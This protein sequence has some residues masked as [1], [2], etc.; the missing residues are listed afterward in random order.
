MTCELCCI[1]LLLVKYILLQACE[2]VAAVTGKSF[3]RHRGVHAEMRIAAL[4][5]NYY[6]IMYCKFAKRSLRTTILVY[7]SHYDY[8]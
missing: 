1:I 2:K 4:V 6:R 8:Y 5:V 3:R 7:H